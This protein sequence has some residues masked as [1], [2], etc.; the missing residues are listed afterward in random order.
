MLVPFVQIHARSDS[1][2]QAFNLK[3]N[4]QVKPSLQWTNT[5]NGARAGKGSGAASGLVRWP[6]TFSWLLVLFAKKKNIEIFW[7]FFLLEQKETKIQERT[8]TSSF[9]LPTCQRLYFP[10]TCSSLRSFTSTR[11]AKIRVIYLAFK[12]QLFHLSLRIITCVES[13]FTNW[14]ISTFMQSYCK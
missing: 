8:P 2:D 4:Y 6:M 10:K 1:S 9:S 5:K 14:N 7:T 11:K 3:P 13:S 12:L